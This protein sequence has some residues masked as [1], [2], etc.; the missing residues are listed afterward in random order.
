MKLRLEMSATLFIRLQGEL[1]L[2]NSVSSLL[3]KT[4]GRRVHIQNGFQ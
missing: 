1:A 4:L 3:P 2:N